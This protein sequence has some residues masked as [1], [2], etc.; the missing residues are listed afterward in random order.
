MYKKINVRLFNELKEEINKSI[1]RIEVPS[2]FSRLL[3]SLDDI[4]YW[5]SNELRTFLLYYSHIILKGKFK[6]AF[7]QHYLLL[8]YAI[9]L[10]VNPE[11]YILNNEKAK[12]LL[13][14]I[15]RSIHFY[16]SQNL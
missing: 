14:K 2:E 4:E 5:K 12:V 16:M 13:E 7:Y 9:R 15:I 10:L 3:K 11:T 1:L 6:K 8:F